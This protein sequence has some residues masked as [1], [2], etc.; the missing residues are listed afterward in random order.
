MSYIVRSNANMPKPKA[1]TVN[2]Q[3]EL[4]ARSK[5]MKQVTRRYDVEWL[6][7]TGDTDSRT[8]V[9]PA[10]QVFEEAFSAFAQG[11]LI[12]TADGYVAIDDLQPGDKIATADGGTQPLLWVGSMT[13]YPH[14]PEL[15]LPTSQ[16]YRLTD[17]SF[18]RDRLAPDLML[19][20]SARIM[21]GLLAI[22]STSN[23]VSIDE[24]AD[25]YSVIKISPMSAVRV[26]HLC[27]ANHHLIRANGVLAETFHPGADIR[28]HM[29]HEMFE[30]Y[31]PLFPH[32]RSEADFGPLNH[33]RNG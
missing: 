28:M 25:G 17:G 18:G 24:A 27:L 1:W 21:S 14:N 20:P 2:R 16:L 10:L 26:F 22:D 3:A 5:Q 32:L 13:V 23:L 12:Q 6:T 30:L 11:T 4:E 7:A 9:A 8:A 19:G 29:S 15:G 33:K 31:M